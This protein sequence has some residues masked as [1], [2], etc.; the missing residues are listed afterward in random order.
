[1]T[2]VSGSSFE[3]SLESTGG[4]WR[5]MVTS[6]NTPGI[7]VYYEVSGVDTPWGPLYQTA[8]PIPA[9]VITEMASTILQIQQQLAPLLVLDNPSSTSFVVIITEGDPNLSVASIPFFNGGAF[10]SSMTVTATP[11]APWLRSE[12]GQRAN[13][14]KN[15]PSNFAITLLTGSLLSTNSPYLGVVNL[16]DNRIPSTLIPIAFSITVLPRPSIVT[17]VSTAAFT[18]YQS[19]STGTGPVT[20]GVGNSGGPSSILYWSAAKLTG[21]SL[22]FG[23]TPASGGPLASGD[24][25]PVQLSLS[26][27][28]IPSLP[29]LYKEK[30]RFSSPNSLNGPLDVEVSLT[31]LAP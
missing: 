2:S 15:E 19:T 20:V 10:G 16:Q 11:G 29:G 30:L 31:V 13:L 18:W 9:D 6:R 26:P 1:M 3:F 17:S 22:W 7:G 5:W 28:N 23:F 21:P 12:P 25:E 4:L 24:S 27:A 8:I 14:G